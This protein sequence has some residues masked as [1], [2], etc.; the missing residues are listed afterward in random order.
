MRIEEPTD[1]LDFQTKAVEEA[2]EALAPVRTIGEFYGR[3]RK[4]FE[5]H[6]DEFIDT[7][8]R[9]QQPTSD[10]LELI[11]D[12]QRVTSTAKALATIDLIVEQG[13]LEPQ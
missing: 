1:P 9:N 3:I 10:R 2:L 4:V 5:K 8:T 7:A 6:G 13:G 12:E 11:E